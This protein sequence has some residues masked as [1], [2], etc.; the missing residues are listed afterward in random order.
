V[1][2]SYPGERPQESGELQY[3]GALPPWH[4][5][6][7]P[8][9]VIRDGEL[10]CICGECPPPPGKTVRLEELPE[11]TPGWTVQQLTRGTDS[12]S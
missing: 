6:L 3:R 1:P 8:Q 4:A 10:H 5:P 11:Q 2:V 9:C 7:R 12:V